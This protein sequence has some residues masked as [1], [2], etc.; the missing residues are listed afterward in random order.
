MSLELMQVVVVQVAEPLVGQ[1]GSA[2]EAEHEFLPL[3]GHHP[4]LLHQIH[5]S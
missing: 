1:P 2:E 5:L 3:H 4:H